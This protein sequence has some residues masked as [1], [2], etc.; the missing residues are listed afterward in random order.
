MYN[1]G[2]GQGGVRLGKT[3]DLRTATEGRAIDPMKRVVTLGICC[4]AGLRVSDTVGLRARAPCSRQIA[5]IVPGNWVL[6]RCQDKDLGIRYC[7]IYMYIYM[8][9]HTH[10]CT[11]VHI[12]MP[13]QAYAGGT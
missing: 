6:G 8:H 4:G 5:E 11:H 7:N 13:V 2:D 1:G 10:V 12:C 3:Q 9:M